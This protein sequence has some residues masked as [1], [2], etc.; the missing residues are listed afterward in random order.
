MMRKNGSGSFTGWLAMLW[1]LLSL[2]VTAVPI[3]EDGVARAEIVIPAQPVPIVRLAAEELATYLE[4]ISGARLPIVT[5]PSAEVPVQVYVGESE[6]TRQLGVTAEGLKHGAYRMVSGDT[7][8]AL[9]GIDT[10]Y[11][12]NELFEMNRYREGT[13]EK[14]QMWREWYKQSGGDWGLPYSQ[15]FKMT[16]DELQ[17]SEHDERGSFNAVSDF[18]RSLGV[19]WYL[20]DP[21]G[22]I[23]PEMD[24]IALPEIDKTVVPD[25]AMRY[26]YQYGRRFWGKVDDELMWQL[27]Q[28]FCQAPDLVDAGY[29]AHGTNFITGIKGLSGRLDAKPKPESYYALIGGKR[30]TG[31][32]KGKNGPQCFSSEGLF[33]DSVAWA[34]AMYDVMDAPMISIMPADGFT[35]A[36]EC[37]ACA[38]QYQRERG[39]R[40]QYSNYVWGFVDRVARELHKTHPDRKVVA[41]AYTTYMLPPD[42]LDSLSPN[43]MVCIAQGRARFGQQP[44]LKEWHHQL[45]RDFLKLFPDDGEKRICVY[46]YYRL[47]VP[48][49]GFAH[50][51]TFYPRAIA[52]DLKSLK[53]VSIGDYIEVYR[54]GLSTM[55]I[56]GVNLW[57]T[58]RFWWDTDQDI[59]AM[60]EEYYTLYYGPA[61]EEM[62]AL[63]EWSEQNFLEMKD[64]DQIDHFFTL[65]QAAEAKAPADSVYAERIAL[66]SDYVAPLTDL[67]AQLAK[68]REGVPELTVAQ[69]DLD[70]LVVDGNLDDAFW[71][72]FPGYASSQLKELF[73]GATPAIGT[74][75]RVAV[76]G[77]NLCFAIRCEDPDMEGV[78]STAKSDDDTSIWNGDLIEILLETQNHSYYQLAISPDGKL[79]DLDRKNGLTMLWA[80][81]AE[82]ATQRDD[83][84]WTIEIRIPI[85]D[86]MQR[87]L[88]ALNGLSGRLPTKTY[89]WYFNVCRQRDR[90]GERDF[91]AFSPTGKSGFHH[92]LKFGRL[93]AR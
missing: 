87:N 16:N 59:D 1:C 89:P 8:L 86:E 52:E 3:V 14:D 44:E 29:L 72:G 51:P 54:S 73:T 85:A 17:I 22:E 65:L 27:R 77:D 40:G 93:L 43:I 15:L 13:P 56:M 9:V 92:P 38:S 76:A 24:T 37:E 18:L 68:G 57:I 4:R 20:P 91:S 21:L 61:R 66:L 70:D 71:A 5:S 49:K 47:S 50:M 19:R 62:K 35:A 12:R 46:E 75:F 63:I 81:N 55:G 74:T 33:R 31:V 23:V 67:R 80:S 41:M 30:R 39:W 7:W 64:V 60:L 69:R 45:R 25:F 6:L 32:E 10:P 84:G 58:S 88:D 79:V 11:Q 42:N 34:R 53:D 83:T 36:C 82:V 78:R 90:D 28:G 2:V 48:G 26:P